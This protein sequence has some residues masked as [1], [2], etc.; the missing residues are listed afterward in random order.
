[1]LKA[2]VTGRIWSTK[3]LTEMPAGSI[4]EVVVDDS[5]SKL[6]AF[7]PLGCGEGEKVIVA[8]GSVA[9]GWFPGKAPPIDA[10]IIGSID[11]AATKT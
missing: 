11:D 5:S 3:K 8:T 2:T 10:L 7:D 4:L 1:M 9:A 6:L